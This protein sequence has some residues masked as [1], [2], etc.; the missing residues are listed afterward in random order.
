MN[1]AEGTVT[2]RAKPNLPAEVFDTVFP[3]YIS[4]SHDLTIDCISP[5]LQKIIPNVSKGRLLEHAFSIIIPTDLHKLNI[6]WIL[7]NHDQF[8]LIQHIKTGL[9]LRG[10]IYT[11]TENDTFLFLCTPWVQGADE[12]SEHGLTL[13]DFAVHDGTSDML[14]L[15]QMHQRLITETRD[16]TSRLKESHNLLRDVNTDLNQKVMK[17][18]QD[19]NNSNELLAQRNSELEQLSQSL[20]HL[21]ENCPSILYRFSPSEDQHIYIS[22]NVSSITG[23]HWQNFADDAQL[24][25]SIIHKDDLEKAKITPRDTQRMQAGESIQRRFRIQHK[26]GHYIHMSDT[27]RLIVTETMDGDIVVEYVGAMTDVSELHRMEKQLLIRSKSLYLDRMT[28]GVAHGCNNK[29]GVIFGH[30][31]ELTESLQKG[32]L[33]NW[34]EHIDGASVA[35]NKIGDLAQAMQVMA[36]QSFLDIETVDVG[37]LIN[38]LRPVIGI[39]ADDTFDIRYVLDADTLLV[40]VDKKLLADMLCKIIE[41]SIEAAYSRGAASSKVYKNIITIKAS[42]TYID[43]AEPDNATK[44]SMFVIIEVTDNAGGI[45]LNAIEHAF[46]PFFSSKE[47]STNSG[48]GLPMVRGSI[49]QMGGFVKL[50]HITNGMSVKIGLPVRRQPIWD[51]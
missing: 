31:D 35:A 34:M 39:M 25:R 51:H 38:N 16:L 6:Q 45:P 42:K 44:H 4:L 10:G 11:I 9:K 27:M 7:N 49:E 28:S 13:G 12:L 40:K 1:L 3:F 50:Q 14:M 46:E 2:P 48:L 26:L 20:N 24:W 5:R 21:V 22:P 43:V 17:R 37:D 19:L 32:R 29:L 23:R 18:T 33:D 30:L 15:L 47:R 41:N 8:I 36:G